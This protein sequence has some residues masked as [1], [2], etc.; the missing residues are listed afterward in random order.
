VAAKLAK[1]E[2]DYAELR[3]AFNQRDEE[4][5]FLRDKSKF[6][7]EHPELGPAFLRALE[8]GG[9]PETPAETPPS[10]PPKEANGTGQ[11]D[12]DEVIASGLSDGILDPRKGAAALKQAIST[13]I[14]QEVGRV[15]AEFQAEVTPFKQREYFQAWETASKRYEDIG[16]PLSRDT[17]EGQANLMKVRQAHFRVCDS[18]GIPRET[19]LDPNMVLR[20]AF[21]DEAMVLA[22]KKALTTEKERIKTNKSSQVV[23]SPGAPGVEGP[24]QRG[25]RARGAQ[26]ARELGIS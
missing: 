2:K 6:V 16:I 14:A 3:S 26:V 21:F 9:Q 4:I 12:I 7:D 23:T 20:E 13:A 18:M 24:A 8:L 15:R 17:K 1:A 10:T 11:V 19:V 5:R 25:I 22:G